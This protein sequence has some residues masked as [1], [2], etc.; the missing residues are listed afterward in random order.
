[1]HATSMAI[2]TMALAGLPALAA[3]GP[4]QD[5]PESP[6]D[7]RDR[8]LWDQT[9]DPS[10]RALMSQNFEAALDDYDAQAA[11][12]FVLAGVRGETRKWI[13]TEVAARGSINNGPGVPTSVNVI[14]Y[15]DRASREY[16][17]LPGSVKQILRNLAY[18]A[19]FVGNL[20]IP[21]PEVPLDPGVRYWISVQ[22]NMDFHP[23]GQWY[24]QNRTT[25]NLGS[26]MWRNPRNGW[27]SGC[28]TWAAEWRCWPD[29]PGDHMFVLKGFRSTHQE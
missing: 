29:I 3:T 27:G 21:L 2:A 9:A 24:W 20:T 18:V 8:V 5:M 12:D 22:A 23:D 4:V 15:N 10:N 16:P 19:D 28:T 14:F 26:A 1:M 7:R 13:L 25:S 11:D 17:H 6:S